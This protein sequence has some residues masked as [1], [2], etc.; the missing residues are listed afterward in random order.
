MAC[1]FIIYL[2]ISGL[3][4]MALSWGFVSAICFNIGLLYIMFCITAGSLIIC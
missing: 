2:S 1:G 3:S 4:S